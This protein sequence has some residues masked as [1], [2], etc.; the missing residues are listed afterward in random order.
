MMRK[1]LI[2]ILNVFIISLLHAQ[3]SIQKRFEFKRLELEN[4]YKWVG[5]FDTIT[6]IATIYNNQ[7]MGYVDTNGTE[8]LPLGPYET[9][10]F[11]NDF[12]VYRN[13]KSRKIYIIDKYGK[14][15]N[16]YS[17][18]YSLSGF[19]N[20]FAIFG[21]RHNDKTSYGILDKNGNEIIGGKY[22][23]LERISNQFLLAQNFSY[24]FGIINIAGDTIVPFEYI[25]EYFDTINKTFI[26]YKKDIGFGVFDSNFTMTK[27][28][29]KEVNFESVTINGKH[30]TERNGVIIIKSKFSSIQSE[31]ALVNTNFDTIVPMGK[32]F[33]LSDTNEDLIK[34]SQSITASKSDPHLTT[35]QYTQCGFINTKGDVVI[36][37]KFDFADYFSEGLC[38]VRINGKYGFIDK[39]GQMAIPATFDYCLP[40]Q[41]GYAK[42][43]IMDKFYIIDKTGKIVLNSKSYY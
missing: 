35:Y 13:I 20:G 16:E 34:F 17:K 37:A 25:I 21:E 10:N 12:G 41:H 32:F 26:G 2:A 18:L 23:Y 19:Y 24:D 31:Y 30:Y 40:F 1:I 28:V 39:S 14:H 15:I 27:F 4:K 7:N 36:E 11:N 33:H 8:I 42:V 3:T 38:V 22:K 5:T 43:Q 6:G 9:H 29:G